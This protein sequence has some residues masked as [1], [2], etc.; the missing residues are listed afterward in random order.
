MTLLFITH[1]LN[2]VFLPKSFRG[3]G[4]APLK[5]QEGGPYLQSPPNPRLKLLPKVVISF[6][7]VIKF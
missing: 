5:G 3:G 4:T 7:S 1:T 6:S 2:L